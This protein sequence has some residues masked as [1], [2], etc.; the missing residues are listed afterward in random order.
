MEEWKV[1]QTLFHRLNTTHT[2]D[3]NDKEIELTEDIVSHAIDYFK[4]RDKGWIY[5]SK[6][7]MVGICYARWLAEHFGGIALEYLDDPD[8]LFGNDPYFVEYSRDPKPY[9]QILNQIGWDFDETQG[10][11]PDVK[12]YFEEEFMICKKD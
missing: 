7:Y 8:L 1:R 3:L 6:S 11:V 9:H 4:S 10:M 12:Q 5:P 2:D